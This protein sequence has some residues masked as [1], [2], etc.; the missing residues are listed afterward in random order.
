MNQIPTQIFLI[1]SHSFRHPDHTT[2][3]RISSHHITSHL[4]T[5]HLIS[6]HLIISHSFR[7]P[8]HI[9]PHH[10]SSH[11][12]SSHHISS[13]LI[14]SHLISSHLIISFIHSFF[15]S[16]FLIRSQERWKTRTTR[17]AS[18]GCSKRALSP[19]P[20][21]VSLQTASSTRWTPCERVF[22]PDQQRSRRPESLN[23]SSLSAVRVIETS[24]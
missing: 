2:P 24:C 20:W 21:R 23:V 4:I 22:R 7:H 16:F 1:I 18:S 8:D 6:S 11:H 12:I 17:P 19:V 3:H 15:L 13:H 5:S 10:I 9:T 14:S